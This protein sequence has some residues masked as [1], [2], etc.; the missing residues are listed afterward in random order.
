MTFL[1]Q[2]S[3]G[4]LLISKFRLIDLLDALAPIS[5]HW[6]GKHKI[7]QVTP[8]YYVTIIFC[9]GKWAL[10]MEIPIPR[11][12]WFPHFR[13]QNNVFADFRP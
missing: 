12:W 10:E 7:S 3:G 2:L 5:Y 11:G 8:R 4:I 6:F 13:H 1:T 9:I